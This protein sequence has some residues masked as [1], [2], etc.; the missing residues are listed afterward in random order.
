[1]ELAEAIVVVLINRTGINNS[2]RKA[3]PVT[4]VFKEIGVVDPA[5]LKK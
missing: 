5:V 2:L 1:M 4:P 3:L